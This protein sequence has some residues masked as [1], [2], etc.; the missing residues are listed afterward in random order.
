MLTMLQYVPI[1]PECTGALR[2]SLSM[3]LS[4]NVPA[5]TFLIGHPDDVM[6]RC[7]N[8]PDSFSSLA[9]SCPQCRLTRRHRLQ[10]PSSQDGSPIP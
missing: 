3:R 4:I 10:L 7:L 6:S 9:F 5:T 2:H 1:L 8:S